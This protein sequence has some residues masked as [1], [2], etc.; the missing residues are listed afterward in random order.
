M[1]E[2]RI[3][4][5]RIEELSSKIISMEKRMDE[6]TASVEKLSHEVSLKREEL[7]QAAKK[8]QRAERIAAHLEKQFK[9]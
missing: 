3:L 5:A 2:N 8:Y 4:K 1:N 6:S 9:V 7:E